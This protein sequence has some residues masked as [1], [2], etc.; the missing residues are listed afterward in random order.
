MSKIIVNNIE[1]IKDLL[2]FPK[3]NSDVY[4]FIQVIQR[5]KEN[6]D[7]P[8][9][10]IQR[11]C[12]WA[13]SI[14]ELDNRLP[15]II[16]VCEKYNARAYISC[17][18]RSIERFTKECLLELTLR[19]CTENYDKPWNIQKKVAL[20]RCTAKTKG[21]IP[22][23]YWLL[24]VDSK[25]Q[26]D[27]VEI[28]NYIGKYTKVVKTLDSLNGYHIVIEAFDI[29][30]LKD[31]C[32]SKCRDDYELPMGQKFTLQKDCNTILYASHEG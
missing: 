18:P 5:R 2:V 12:V 25:D 15:R 11:H 7:L 19:V 24:D 10:E 1:K 32:V 4:Y 3:G 23:P 29:T 14:A 8:V 21:V 20:R 30:K 26:D 9:N 16:A 6:P 13:N 28:E 17:I 22:K 27:C 31:V